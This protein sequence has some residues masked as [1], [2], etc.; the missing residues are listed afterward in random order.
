[1]F[2]RI[3][4]TP[5]YLDHEKT[6]MLERIVLGGKTRHEFAKTMYGDDVV[7]L[8]VWQEVMARIHAL[9]VDKLQHEA[10][11]AWGEFLHVYHKFDYWNDAA[12]RNTIGVIHSYCLATSQADIRP[13]PLSIPS[14]IHNRM[15]TDTPFAHPIADQFVLCFNQV[16][17]SWIWR[18]LRTRFDASVHVCCKDV[19]RIQGSLSSFEIRIRGALIEFGAGVCIDL[20][21]EVRGAEPTDGPNDSSATPVG[22]SDSSGGGHDR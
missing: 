11:R 6:D 9:I 21:P 17:Q 12:S 2:C 18:K 19:S 22:N 7:W 1:M 14:H 4:D 13:A 15:T 10:D 16:P 20:S 8:D 5:I 3:N